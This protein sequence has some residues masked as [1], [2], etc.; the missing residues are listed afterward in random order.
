MSIRH[1]YTGTATIQFSICAETVEDAREA[2]VDILD[3]GSVADGKYIIHS[4]E[5]D[6]AKTDRENG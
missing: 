1:Y 2:M 5:Y 3:Q 6:R 4:V